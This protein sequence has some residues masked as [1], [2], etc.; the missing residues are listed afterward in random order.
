MKIVYNYI[1][2]NRLNGKL[3]VKCYKIIIKFRRKGSLK[4]LGS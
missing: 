3:G 1:N 4:H 2:I